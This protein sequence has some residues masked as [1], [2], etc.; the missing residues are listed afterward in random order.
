MASKKR[1]AVTVN[2]DSL[3]IFNSINPNSRQKPTIFVSEIYRIPQLRR[4]A[5]MP[6]RTLN[7]IYQS[8]KQRL[9]DTISNS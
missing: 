7:T 1:R 5:G 3:T 2:V 9:S 8:I 4:I 6:I